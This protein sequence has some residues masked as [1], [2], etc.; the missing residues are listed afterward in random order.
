VIAP[1]GQLQSKW[2]DTGE[3]EE[4]IHKW[5][6]CDSGFGFADKRGLSIEMPF[7]DAT[8]ILLLKTDVPHPRLGNGLLGILKIPHFSKLE[9]VNALSIEMNFLEALIWSKIGMPLIGN[10]TSVES[11]APGEQEH[12]FVPAF[13]SFIP[14]LVY[15][16]GLAETLVLYAMGRARWVREMLLPGT[17]DLPM[18]E[19]LS[20][21]LNREKSS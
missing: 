8:A 15:Q 7:G 13:S 3:F 16:P 2:I 21:R 14:N 10:W 5:G 19:I 1:Q 12:G 6:R 9:S 20:K 17:L 18:H 11:G 4:I